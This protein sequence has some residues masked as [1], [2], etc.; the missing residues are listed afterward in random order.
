MHSA[1]CLIF[2]QI[3]FSTQTASAFHA[4][5]LI[6][7]FRQHP[8]N[9]HAIHKPKVNEVKLGDKKKKGPIRKRMKSTYVSCRSWRG[10][11]G[12]GRGGKPLP[13]SEALGRGVRGPPSH[14]QLN[15]PQGQSPKTGCKGYRVGLEGARVNVMTPTRFPPLHPLP[16]PPTQ[17]SAPPL[18]MARHNVREAEHSQATLN[19]S[20][21]LEGRARSHPVVP[22]GQVSQKCRQ[23]HHLSSPT[24]SLWAKLSRNGLALPSLTNNTATIPTSDPRPRQRPGGASLRKKT[25]KKRDVVKGFPRRQ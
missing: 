24:L 20:E 17:A 10:Y 4:I 5:C 22:Q 8:H 18:S 19:G 13:F 11:L 23:G 25:G 16:S 1:L 21:T 2:F 14:Q 3:S 9:S 7:P 6:F 15:I 12:C